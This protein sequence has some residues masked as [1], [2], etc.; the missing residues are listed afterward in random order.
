MKDLHSKTVLV[1]G[2]DYDKCQRVAQQYGFRNVVTPGDIVTAHPEIWPFSKVFKGYYDGFAK[3]L[4]APIDKDDA[5]KSLK[6]DAVFVYSDPRDWGLDATVILDLLLSREGIMGTVSEKNGDEKL[7][8]RGYLQDGQPPLYFSN[9]DLWWAAKYHL[10]RLGQGGFRES[11][12]GLWRA[13]TGGHG[14]E[15]A[16]L[17]K[18]VIGKPSQLTYEFAEKRLRSHRADIYAAETLKPLRKV[19]MV[20]DNPGES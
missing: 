17:T 10:S 3:P 9:P 1:V 5:S 15:P 8:N 16:E 2:G 11:L 12:E 14:K 18:T 20:G 19:Y 7:P 13:V 6:I 4:P